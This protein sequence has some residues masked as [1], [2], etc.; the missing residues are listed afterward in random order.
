M[1]SIQEVEVMVAQQCDYIEKV[2][3]DDGAIAWFEGGHLDPWDHVEAAMALTI[4]G[5][6]SQARL[7]YEWLRIN[8]LDDGSWGIRYENSVITDASRRESNFVAYVAVGVWHYYCCTGDLGFVERMWP[9]VYRAL[10]FVSR[11]QTKEGDICWAV[12]EAGTAMKDALVTGCSSIYKSF[13]C[14]IRLAQTL[15]E[16]SHQFESVYHLLGTALRDRPERFDRTWAPKTR[17]SMDWFYPVLCGAIKGK[18]AYQRIGNRW[19]EFVEEGLGC[20]CVSD[21]PW[22]T[23]AESC[24]LVMALAAIGDTVR[25]SDLLDWL[26]QWRDVDGVHW[27]GW[28]FVNKEYWPL[29]KPTWTSGAFVL[30]LDSL[31]NITSASRIFIDTIERE[32][33]AIL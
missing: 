23:V 25:A 14:G 2:Q 27:T 3:Q 30:A 7:A 15:G 22:I 21:E 29:E 16:N 5:R 32:S 17:F 12:D 11:L 4:G 24:E 26:L 28:Q 8:Q 19:N 31:Y 18:E 9:T 10:N 20:R 6:T 33:V 13:E 1:L